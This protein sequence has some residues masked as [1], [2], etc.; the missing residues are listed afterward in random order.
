MDCRAIPCASGAA[1][2]VQDFQTDHGKEQMIRMVED[3]PEN[4]LNA[5]QQRSK[6]ARDSSFSLGVCSK[7]TNQCPNGIIGI[8]C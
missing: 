7:L 1:P 8:G 5:K 2:D 6:D 4:T 3:Y